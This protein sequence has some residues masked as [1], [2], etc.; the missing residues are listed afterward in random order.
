MEHEQSERTQQPDKAIKRNSRTKHPSQILEQNTRTKRLSEM[1]DRNVRTKHPIEKLQAGKLQKIH[2]WL[3]PK[4]AQNN[5]T[6][7]T[8]ATL[9]NLTEQ[10]IG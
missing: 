3:Q 1:I 7:Q 5:R 8:P 6:K 4:A 2:Y 9:N 10:N